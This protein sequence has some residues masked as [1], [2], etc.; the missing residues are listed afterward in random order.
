MKLLKLE[1]WYHLAQQCP[2]WQASCQDEVTR[3]STERSFSCAVCCRYFR[4]HSGMKRHKWIVECQLPLCEQPGA[5]QCAKCHRWLRSRSGL[6]IHKCLNVSSSSSLTMSSSSTLLSIRSSSLASTDCTSSRIP[7]PDRTCCCCHCSQCGRCFKSKPGFQRH[8]C[9]RG[10][11]CSEKDSSQ[12]PLSCTCGRR[13]QWLK[14]I[15]R[16]KCTQ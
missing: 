3:T 5:V 10:K 12:L 16:H 4:S 11:R 2:E 9:H 8:N 1:N 14:N 13:L 7:E 15:Q 6:A